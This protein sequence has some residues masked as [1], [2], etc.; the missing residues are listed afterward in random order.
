MRFVPFAA[1][2]RRASDRTTPLQPR[3]MLLDS[4]ES[5]GTG[6]RA[7]LRIQSRKGSGFESPLSHLLSRKGLTANRRKSFFAQGQVPPDASADCRSPGVQAVEQHGE[8]V[9]FA[10]RTSDEELIGG[11]GFDGMTKGHRA[12]IGYWLAKPHWGQGIMASVVGKAC[13]HAFVRWKLVRITAHVFHFN[14]AS[15]SVL[16]KNGFV[17]EGDLRKHYRKDGQFIDGKLYA[18]V[19]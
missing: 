9:H 18:L 3:R 14:L 15:A 5:G 11:C 7:G 16:E 13:E 6:R 2:R 1:T 17:F 19:H 12:E 4:R 8:P 10:I